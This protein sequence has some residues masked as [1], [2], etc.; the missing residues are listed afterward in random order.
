MIRWYTSAATE[1]FKD[2][3]Q[4]Y[5]LSITDNRVKKSFVK[6]EKSK[7]VFDRIVENENGNFFYFTQPIIVSEELFVVIS[8]MDCL[9]GGISAE[10]WKY[11]KIN[12]SIVY[13][14]S[15]TIMSYGIEFR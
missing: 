14:K 3:L 7:L 11:D 5:Q 13:I 15:C 8:L 9:G 6:W 4:I 1:L 12:N 10:L 2:T